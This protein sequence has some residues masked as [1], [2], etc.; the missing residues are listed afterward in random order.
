MKES[1]DKS[2]TT[3][4]GQIER[5]TYSDG[6]FVIAKV[7]VPLHKD[8]VTVV[9]NIP[10]PAPGS[11]L[12]MRGEWAKHP[13][14]GVQFKVT[15][16]TCAV[17]A[18]IYGITKYLQSGLIKGIGPSM[19]QRIVE[20]FGE[21]TLD[22]IEHSAEELLTIEGIGAHRVK[23]IQDAWSEQREI[24]D[25]MMFLQSYDVSTA[26]ATKIFQKYGS[27]SIA[28]V[29]ENPYRLSTD[30]T[31]IGFLTAD[32]I[33]Q[34]LGVDVNSQMRAEA[35]IL[36]ILKEFNN[37][38][39]VYCPHDELIKKSNDVLHIS[40]H[41]LLAA[42][43]S[44]VL[45]NRI[46]IERLDAELGVY[47]V[48]FYISE[49]KVAA[50]L[51]SLR[52]S[53]SRL[54]PIPADSALE[55]VQK[56]ISVVLAEKQKEAIKAAISEK[57]LVITGSPGTGKTTIT[58]AILEVLSKSTSK[59]I[60]TAPT[61]R[62][63]KRISETTGREAKTIH[64]L[65]EYMSG[66]F[67]RNENNP[68]DCDVV[69]LDEASMVDIWLMYHLLCAIPDYATLIIVG[70]INQ[71]PSVGPGSVLKD[72]INSGKITVVQLNEIFRQ[73]QKSMIIMNAH[74]IIN[75][76]CPNLENHP[77]T[78]FF[79][80]NKDDP[81][82]AQDTIVR[83]IKDRI[84]RK[85]GF[86]PISDV[87]VL[88]PMHR[89]AIGTD[90]LNMVLQQA[91]NPDGIELVRGN[92][93]FRVGDKVMQVKNNYDKDVFNGDIGIV[94]RVDSVNQTAVVRMDERNVRYESGEL[95]EL[96]LSYAVS[97]HKS[98]GSEYPVV[99]I[100]LFRLH[101]IMLQRNLV[102][103]GITRGKKLVVVV[104]TPSALS[105]AIN[106]NQTMKRN[107]W[108]SNRLVAAAALAKE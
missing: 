91:L 39:H 8:L 49:T 44:L 5:I 71:L 34:K 77:G 108:L 96:V 7:K 26:H 85:F 50:K 29:K 73:A 63:A 107:T 31:G 54:E 103:T 58:K 76:D 27:E 68:L 92:R 24:R 89:G 6:S 57:L 30:I 83:L 13:K 75:G 9:G 59:I 64:R 20:K 55:W 11:V 18:S 51:M 81:D 41:I 42:L 19:A 93:R 2:T 53:Q 74:K 61:G 66:A 67:Q 40:E 95:D 4:K 43:Q 90:N 32:H 10:S 87:Q 28:M 60:L 94:E 62:A 33:A 56:K 102:Y 98:Q 105:A 72:I 23:M 25:V 17:P 16:C 46:V 12:S 1:T 21:R 36:H 99:V 37:E 79:F 70:D 47:L 101:Y 15:D 14:F 78:D 52:H 86:R 65:L 84:P 104:G 100:P 35:G 38:G 3:L 22:V 88:T 82:E 45:G 80:I 106:N 69:I 48:G 97:I